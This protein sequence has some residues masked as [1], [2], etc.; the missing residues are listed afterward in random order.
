MHKPLKGTYMREIR[1]RKLNRWELAWIINNGIVHFKGH[2]LRWL[3]A[4]SCTQ[5]HG[6][7]AISKYSKEKTNKNRSL[8]NQTMSEIETSVDTKS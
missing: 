5:S 2:T 4:W 6:C 3:A 1:K 8:A 7:T